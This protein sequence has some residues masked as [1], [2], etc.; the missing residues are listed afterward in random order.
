M[1][2]Q[3]VARIHPSAPKILPSTAMEFAWR[4][5]SHEATARMK[6]MEA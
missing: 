5:R 2:A 3:L 1:N 6:R 4:R